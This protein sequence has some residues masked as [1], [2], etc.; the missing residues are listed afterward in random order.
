MSSIN[1]YYLKN[2][3]NF[4]VL[5]VFLNSFLLIDPELII[6]FSISFVIILSVSNLSE[7]FSKF[8]NLIFINYYY[9]YIKFFN[10]QLYFL[11]ELSKFLNLNLFLNQIPYY[12]EYYSNFIKYIK[13]FFVFNITT[14]TFLLNYNFF[15]LLKIIKNFLI[16]FYL[17]YYFLI[18][19]QINYLFPKSKINNKFILFKYFFNN[20]KKDRLKKN[21]KY[22]IN[23]FKNKFKIKYGSNKFSKKNFVFTEFADKFT[24][25]LIGI[26]KKK[27]KANSLFVT[28]NSIRVVEKGKEQPLIKK[29]FNIFR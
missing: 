15:R 18:I 1:L 9:N 2:F 24:F 25:N 17:N 16:K 14:W 4:F 11:Y 26:N 29:F 23:L 27:I 5:L 12:I 21:K 8:F 7:I 22:N 28:N 19:D 13:N 6:F 3:F 20:L 10:I